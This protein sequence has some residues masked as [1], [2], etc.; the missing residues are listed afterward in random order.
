MKIFKCNYTYLESEMELVG[1][2]AFVVN[3]GVTTIEDLSQIV[4]GVK[5]T[6]VHPFT[7]DSADIEYWDERRQV[8]DVDTIS[9]VWLTTDTGN[10]TVLPGETVMLN[11]RAQPYFKIGTDVNVT[12]NAAG[13]TPALS[14]SVTIPVRPSP[15]YNLTGL[16]MNSWAYDNGTIYIEVQNTGEGYLEVDEE[17]LINDVEFSIENAILTGGRLLFTGDKLGI[18]IDAEYWGVNLIAGEEVR[19]LLHY[20]SFMPTFGGLNVSIPI[21]IQAAPTPP[22]PPDQAAA[23]PLTVDSAPVIANRPIQLEQRL[24]VSVSVLCVESN[25]FFIFRRYEP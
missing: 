7:L 5:N 10:L 14:A 4:V 2:S 25:S 3:E 21:T 8:Y 22:S 13:F 11:V 9:S 16:P 12:I 20:M 6:G 24:Y 19:V 1:A 15:A 17:G 23:S 18:T